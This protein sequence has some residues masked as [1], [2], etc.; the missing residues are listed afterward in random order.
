MYSRFRYVRDRVK[1][2]LNNKVK[3]SIAPRPIQ[4]HFASVNA[5][6]DMGYLH[7]KGLV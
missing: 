6:R 3:P 7:A 2:A 5:P 4:Y 1:R